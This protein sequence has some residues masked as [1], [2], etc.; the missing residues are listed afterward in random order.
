M[1]LKGLTDRSETWQHALLKFMIYIAL[2]RKGRKAEIEF[3]A[4][5]DSIFDVV[6]WTEGIVYEPYGKLTRKQMQSKTSR[7]LLYSGI[8]DMIPICTKKFK[9]DM[10]V[11]EWIKGI[12]E[13]I[14]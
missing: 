13:E 12:E 14:I 11:K 4:G 5:E 2:R 1:T 10:T 7:Y 3:K 8:K 9:L 6:D